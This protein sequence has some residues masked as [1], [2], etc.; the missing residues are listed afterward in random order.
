MADLSLS[1]MNL[2]FQDLDQKIGF[3]SDRAQ[4]GKNFGSSG[5]SE[6]RGRSKS[7]DN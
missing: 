3:E 5:Y 1:Q 7:P 6:L 4:T 2:I